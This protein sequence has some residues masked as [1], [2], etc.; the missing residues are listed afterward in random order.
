[1]KTRFLCA[2]GLLSLL[3]GGCASEPQLKPAPAA[4]KIA[5]D[6]LGARASV[7]NVQLS[8]RFDAWEWRPQQLDHKLTPVL[9][10]IQNNS[11][12]P[13]R[14]RYEEFRLADPRGFEFVALPPFA[15]D[16]EAEVPT[17]AYAYRTTGFYAA[18]HVSPYYSGLDPWGGPFYYDP[19]F[20]GTYNQVYREVDLPTNDMLIRALPEGVLE[21]NGEVTGFIYFPDMGE[22]RD[23]PL[24]MRMKFELVNAQTG[25]QFGVINIPL[26]LVHG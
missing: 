26:V 15:I 19:G 1:M 9:V 22:D 14:I 6:V 2:I 8:A 16:K 20:Y 24:E 3:V 13:L 17:D 18:P 12:Q 21:P 25:G 4:N 11:D 10:R 7:D 23:L 5:G